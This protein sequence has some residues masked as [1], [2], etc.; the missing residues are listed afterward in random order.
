M[1]KIEPTT[2]LDKEDPKASY[3]LEDKDYLLITAIQE[4]TKAIK[5]LT[6]RLK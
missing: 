5:F 3:K 6:I 2:K 1:E 4:L